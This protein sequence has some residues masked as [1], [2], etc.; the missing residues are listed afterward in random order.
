MT[1]IA[2]SVTLIPEQKAQ[3]KENKNI[4]ILDLQL[5]FHT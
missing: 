1:F 2:P 4:K 5:A 3:Q